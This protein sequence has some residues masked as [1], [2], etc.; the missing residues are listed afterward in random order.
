MEETLKGG[1]EKSRGGWLALSDAEESRMRWTLDRIYHSFHP[2]PL[3]LI[4][5]GRQGWGMG[6]QSKEPCLIIK[7]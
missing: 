1:C 3:Q 5:G 4:P 6:K 2:Q 7:L